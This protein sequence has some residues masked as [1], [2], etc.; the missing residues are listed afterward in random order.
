M[1]RCN[2]LAKKLGK[3]NN[4]FFLVDKKDN[5]LSKLI[6]KNSTILLK[7]DIFN[8]SD[9]IIKILKN[10]KNPIVI[11]DSYLSNLNFEKKIILHSKK[12]IVID[13][14]KKNHFCNIYINPNFLNFNFASKI[15]ADI[16][17]LGPKY[18]FVD[19]LKKKKKIKKSKVNTIKNVLVFMGATDSKN[20]S[21]KIYNAVKEKNI[22]HLNFKFIK[23]YNNSSLES[24]IKK[25]KFKNIKFINFSNKFLNYLNKTDIF[26]SS[27]GSSVWDSV[28]LQKKTLIFNH[29]SKQFENS[30]N[31]ERKGLIKVFKRSL[32][33]KNI[34]NFL[35]SESKLKNKNN[36]ESKIFFNAIGVSE[37][38][39][40]IFSSK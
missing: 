25:N 18:S 20:L 32:T 6:I 15:N 28:F 8:N 23:G 29:S 17:L 22:T 5:S 24:I 21:I 37:I 4:L 38:A 10:L 19:L 36:F 3:K 33:S 31:L 11:I 7:K 34:N 30:F 2:K 1:S 26:I 12:L 14:L 40:K 27:G 13:D 39:K 16:K 35:I 9:K